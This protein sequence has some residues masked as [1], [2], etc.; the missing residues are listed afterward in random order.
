MNVLNNYFKRA[1]QVGYFEGISLN[2]IDPIYLS[3][4][5]YV[6]D[7][8]FIGEWKTSN[9]VSIVYI[10][11]FFHMEFGLPINLQKKQTIGV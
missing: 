11:R 9:F 5:F 3:R 8:V 7:D 10:M 4:L 2:T 6:D 1:M